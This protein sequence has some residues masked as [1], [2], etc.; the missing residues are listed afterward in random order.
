MTLTVTVDAQFIEPYKTSTLKKLKKDLKVDGFRPGHAPDNIVV[1]E[2]GEAR[3]QAEVLEEVIDH[4][5]NNQMREHKIESL[6][7]PSI[8]L[9]KFV[10]YTELEF[11]AEF[12]IA[13]AIDF[14]YSKLKIK[15]PIVKVEP[16]RVDEAIATLQ[17]Q[18]AKRQTTKKPIK[19]GDEV[20][21][22]FEG[23]RAGKLVDGASAKNHTIT[24]GSGSFIPGFE[25]NLVGLKQDDEKIFEVTF[26]KDYHVED[27]KNAKVDF[28]VKINEVF[29]VD[30]PKI[31]DE[32][33]KIVANKP[34][35]KELRADIEKVLAEQS[36]E[37]N[38]KDYENQILDEL[39]KK[40]KF[41]APA[42][43][44]EQQVQQLESEMDKNLENS[45]MDRKKYLEIQKR[46][47]DD[48]K[49]E[50]KAEADKRVRAALLLR[51]VI[52]RYKLTVSELEIDQELAKMAEQ[53]KSD[54]KIQ[55]ELTHGHFREDLNNHLLTQKA[56]AQLT[57]F[58]SA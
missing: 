44:I 46:T 29:A 19:S 58:A 53:Y 26:P 39:L 27:L 23:K 56:I 12:P 34:N 33:A 47:E 4:A 14:D 48:L 10:P 3:V 13:P 20:R 2:L 28:G 45:G 15:K 5:F 54:P 55:E 51:D 7:S 40:T 38:N 17:N 11:K 24:I 18:M 8:D 50:V 49:A 37:Q 30:M 36:Q 16:S 35:V 52:K 42:Q 57:K 25:E 6:G 31:D 41:N 9:V 21:F 32:F 43:L 1:R 22:D